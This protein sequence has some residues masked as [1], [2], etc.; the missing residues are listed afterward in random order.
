MKF[1]NESK[2]DLAFFFRMQE[3]TTKVTGDC[4]YLYKNMRSFPEIGD[5]TTFNH[6]T[7]V[8]LNTEY[9][10]AFLF[11][12]LITAIEMYEEYFPEEQVVVN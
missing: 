11:Q 1:D 3:L 7:T 2:Y 8:S 4:T 10:S 5:F 12:K 9:I 6:T